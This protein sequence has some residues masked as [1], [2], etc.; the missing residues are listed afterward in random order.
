MFQE[1]NNKKLRAL[2]HHAKS[3][4]PWY[5]KTLAK[6]NIE[7]FTRERL[8]ELPTINKT[9]LMENWDAFV[10]NPKL[11][12]K[13]VEHHLS[14]K[15]EEMDT[16]YLF[17]RYHVLS[18]GG[19]SGRRGIFVY[20]WDEW[21]TFHTAYIRFPLYNHARTHLITSQI[22]A[23]PKVVSLFVKNTATVAYSLAKTFCRPDANKY[24]LPMAVMPL[25]IVISRLNQIMPDIL[26]AAPSYLHKVCQ[27]VQKGQIKIKPKIVFVSGEPLFYQ[28]EALIKKTWPEV[29]LFNNFGCTEGMT[30]IS[31][32]ANTDEMHLNEDLCIVEPLD[33]KNKPVDKGVMGSK[34][35]LTNLY[36]YTLPLIRYEN[37]DEILFL[38]KTCDC[39]CEHQLMSAPRGRPGCDFNYPGAI[40]VHHSLFLGP[41]LLEK[42]IQEYL[43]ERVLPV[44]LG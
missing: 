31:C 15:T 43:V 5:K 12:L 22:N 1:I 13:L 34:V 21:I 32:R 11:S 16:L 17:S 18:T 24:F 37:S 27:L 14:K 6:I 41:L 2:L 20:D 35:Y 19:S 25:S 39:G 40:Y 36:N 26:T 23:N 29:N 28:T 33:E 30:G 44:N 10:T 4:S 38:N 3:K 8:S 9:I 42:N 7:D